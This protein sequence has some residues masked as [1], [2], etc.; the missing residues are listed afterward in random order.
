MGS[1]TS[2]ME[3]CAAAPVMPPPPGDRP[4]EQLLRHGEKVK[5]SPQMAARIVVEAQ[6][7]FHAPPS[8]RTVDLL[9]EQLRAGRLH[10]RR[11]TFARLDGKLTLVDG[12]ASLHAVMR[13]GI[14]G[15]LKIR[16]R[17]VGS[18][19]ELRVLAL[20][21]R[22]ATTEAH[23][24]SASPAPA[25]P[26]RPG[27]APTPVNGHPPAHVPLLQILQHGRDAG[28][29]RIDAHAATDRGGGVERLLRGPQAERNSRTRRLPLPDRRHPDR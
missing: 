9:A 29:R 27:P 28:P 11:L 3:C 14:A 26:P 6:C 23:T 8:N 1:T 18:K 2:L 25:T 17:P 12:L 13:S 21:P 10:A 4:L 7:D 16:V 19:E 20:G 15:R 24:I 5:I 22:A